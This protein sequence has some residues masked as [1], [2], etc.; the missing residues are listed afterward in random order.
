MQAEYPGARVHLTPV[1]VDP[2]PEDHP[3]AR[4]LGQG[5]FQLLF[6]ANLYPG[7]NA[8]V[9]C[10]IVGELR[11]RG[12][13]AS[14]TIIGDGDQRSVVE[15]LI[16]ARELGNHVHLLGK[17][18]N[19]EVFRHL[20]ASHLL[21]SASV[22]EPYG[23]GIA[24][25]MAVGTPCVCHR[26]GGP[27]EFITNNQDGLLVNELT[28]SAFTEA[29]LPV[30]ADPDFWNRLSTESLQTATGWRP[31]VVLEAMEDAFYELIEGSPRRCP[32][33]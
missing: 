13:D 2:L 14:G 5:R 24:E 30:A 29:I 4:W 23:R 17:L 20:R 10:E 11:R 19:S 3:R 31:D 15:E 9:F 7:K 6:V 32:N 8:G 1:I 16:A 21:V 12:V 26:S 33:L 27:S 18:A 28:P 25:A 22:G